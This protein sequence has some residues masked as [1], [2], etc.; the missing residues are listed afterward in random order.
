MSKTDETKTPEPV[1]TKKADTVTALFQMDDKVT[2]LA[3]VVDLYDPCAMPD[4]P[5]VVK[6]DD[7]RFIVAATTGEEIGVLMDAVT[8][9]LSAGYDI[10]TSPLYG[11][12]A[13]VGRV[14]KELN[15]KPKRD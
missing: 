4:A 8:A 11:D 9:V 7:T 6:A 13:T 15:V 12:A 5:F 10:V 2:Q 1:K 3:K 14:W